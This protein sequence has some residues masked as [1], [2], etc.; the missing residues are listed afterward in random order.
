MCRQGC[1]ACIRTRAALGVRAPRKQQVHRWRAR[2]FSETVTTRRIAFVFLKSSRGAK[3]L[4]LFNSL[5]KYHFC[6][7]SCAAH[8]GTIGTWRAR[9]IQCPTGDLPDAISAPSSVSITCGPPPRERPHES[10][11]SAGPM[12]D[13]RRQDLACVH[14]CVCVRTCTSY[15]LLCTGRPKIPPGPLPHKG[16]SA[17]SAS[18]SGT[19]PNSRGARPPRPQKAGARANR[20]GP[21]GRRLRRRQSH[22]TRHIP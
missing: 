3:S 17:V 5:P 9:A 16:T 2:S 11:D 15:Y 18:G 20:R 7:A 10:H 22:V 6:A 19:F 4:Y 1:H 12:A 21:P 8:P 14:R 13:P